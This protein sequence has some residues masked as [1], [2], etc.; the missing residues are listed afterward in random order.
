VKNV[1]EVQRRWR[2]K[3]G[4]PPS[5]QVTITRLRDKFETDG[6]VQNV[7]KGRS[8]RTLS[9]TNNECVAVT[10]KSYQI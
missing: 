1:V 6:V 8:G 4:T 7:N 2:N 3:F 9:S 5:T 10:V